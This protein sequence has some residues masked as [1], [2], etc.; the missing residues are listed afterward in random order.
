M[1]MDA[2]IIYLEYFDFFNWENQNIPNLTTVYAKF[3]NDS[4]ELQSVSD[5]MQCK[6]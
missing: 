6:Q 3:I 4:R 2:D 5:K 1:K